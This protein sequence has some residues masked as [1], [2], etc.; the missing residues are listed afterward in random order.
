[1]YIH[2]RRNRQKEDKKML[3]TKFGIE[4][5]GIT[6]QKAADVVSQLVSGRITEIRDHYDTKKIT[7]ADGRS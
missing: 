4:F 5:T 2:D 7:M 6:R 3:N 1:M